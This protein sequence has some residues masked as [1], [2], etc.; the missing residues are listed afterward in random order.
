[1]TWFLRHFVVN[2]ELP[3]CF[4]KCNYFDNKSVNLDQGTSKNQ[5]LAT[6]QH[7]IADVF[8]KKCGNLQ[9]IGWKYVIDLINII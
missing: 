6:G 3:T 2:M 8:C 4:M 7:T 1:M 9:S 5:N